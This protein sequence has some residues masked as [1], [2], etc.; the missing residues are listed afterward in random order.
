MHIYVYICIERGRERFGPGAS[1]YIAKSIS[2]YINMFKYAYIY[3][4]ICIERERERGGERERDLGGK[5]RSGAPT[6]RCNL[7]LAPAR[8][9]RR[10]RRQ[11]PTYMYNS[12][13]IYLDQ[14]LHLHTCI[15]IFA[16]V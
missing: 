2:I 8:R 15:Y 10:S 13:C 4:Y 5:D 14:Y 16:Y 3:M 11:V 1:L 9:A 7:R 6:E 12:V